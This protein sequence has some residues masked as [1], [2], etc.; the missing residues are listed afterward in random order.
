[1]D[2][3]TP[4]SSRGAGRSCVRTPTSPPLSARSRLVVAGACQQ[5]FRAQR[6]RSASWPGHASP[7]GTPAER[8]PG[9]TSAGIARS[10]TV[11]TTPCIRNGRCKSGAQLPLRSGSGRAGCR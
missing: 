11:Y 8:G 6:R 7:A 9:R 2:R 4:W 5:G 1:M 3:E 10:L